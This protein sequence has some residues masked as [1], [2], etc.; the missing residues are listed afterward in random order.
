MLAAGIRISHVIRKRDIPLEWL[1]F[2]VGGNHEEGNSRQR[3]A[4]AK[5]QSTCRD[6]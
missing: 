3:I 2:S 5:V 6:E 1:L 4:W